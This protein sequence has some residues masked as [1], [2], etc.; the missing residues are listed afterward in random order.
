[1]GLFLKKFLTFANFSL[2]IHIKYKKECKILYAEENVFSVFGLSLDAR[3]RN[4][5]V[6]HGTSDDCHGNKESWTDCS[7]TRLTRATL[8]EHM[9]NSVLMRLT[10]DLLSW[11]EV[12]WESDERNILVCLFI[13]TAYSLDSQCWDVQCE[14]YSVF[15]RLDWTG[16]DL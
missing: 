13:N 1:M 5:P 11:L 7:R 9:R 3:F 8:W 15:S 10:H 2:D 4:P 16:L 14:A 12:I 6:R